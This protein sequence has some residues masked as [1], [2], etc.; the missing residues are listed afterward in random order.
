MVVTAGKGV[1][2]VVAAA[3]TGASVAC[4][5]VGSG[6]VTC[7]GADADA[8]TAVESGCVTCTGAGAG[9]PAAGARGSIA[10]ATLIRIIVSPRLIKTAGRIFFQENFIIGIPFFVTI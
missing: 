2:V 8:C 4:V 1:N 6:C 7:I 10:H 9:V 5:A 3:G